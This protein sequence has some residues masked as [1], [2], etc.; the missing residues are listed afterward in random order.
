MEKDR[1]TLHPAGKIN[2]YLEVLGIRENGY[3]DIRSV[4]VPVS[5]CDALTLERTDKD[6][7]TIVQSCAETQSDLLGWGDEG[8]CP[9]KNLA[10]RAAMALKD[11]T[12]CEGGVRIT[13]QKRIPVGGGLGG[14]SAD[15][16]ATL[17]GLNELWGTGLDLGELM[18]IGAG[19]GCDVP[20]LLQ[21]GAVSMEG[22]GESVSPLPLGTEGADAGW[23]LVILNPGFRVSTGDIYARCTSALTSRDGEFMNMVSALRCGDVNLAGR[24]LF[25]GLQETVFRKYPLVRMLA[26]AL[27]EAGAVGSLVSGS[28]ASVFGLALDEAHARGVAERARERLEVSVWSC[29]SRTLPDGVTVAHGPLEARV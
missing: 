22:M 29:I 9:T 23:H 3:H 19:L 2:L 25:N 10:T 27:V 17:K 24:S 8:L 21:G 7:D 12:G 18:I 14:G 11:A 15:A 1:L 28:G 4:L 6:I 5:L 26:E 16:A 20:A 13:L